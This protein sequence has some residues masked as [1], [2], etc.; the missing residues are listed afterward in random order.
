M[1]GRWIKNDP[2]ISLRTGWLTKKYKNILIKFTCWWNRTQHWLMTLKIIFKHIIAIFKSLK[3][4]GIKV[5]HFHNTNKT[6]T[7]RIKIIYTLI[8]MSLNTKC[9]ALAICWSIIYQ[10]IIFCYWY[11]S[12]SF[13]SIFL[14]I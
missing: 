9:T 3:S 14:L 7:S 12:L 4:V 2:I 6:I 10:I 8:C 13:L 1:S 5:I 11:F